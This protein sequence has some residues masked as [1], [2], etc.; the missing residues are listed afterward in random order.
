MV[1]ARRQARDLRLFPD[2]NESERGNFGRD[3]SRWFGRH[4]DRLGM[5]APYFID[6]EREPGYQARDLPGEE[7]ADPGSLAGAS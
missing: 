4:L 1:E 2:L 7:Q 3:L 6:A 5:T